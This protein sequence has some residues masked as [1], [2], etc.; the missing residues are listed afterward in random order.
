MYHKVLVPLDGSHLSELALP[1]AEALAR[2]FKSENLLVRVCQPGPVPFDLY[3]LGPPD[4]TDDYN[5]AVQAQAEEEARSYLTRIQ[6]RLRLQNIRNRYSGWE[7]LP[8]LPRL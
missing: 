7:E 3:T 2:Q 5:Q 8:P 6:K 1:H 4:V